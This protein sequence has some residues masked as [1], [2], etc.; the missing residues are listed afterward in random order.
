MRKTAM[1]IAAVCLM[2]SIT[3]C[4]AVGGTTNESTAPGTTGNGSNAPGAIE[5]TAPGTASNGSTAPGTGANESNTPEPAA[6]ETAGPVTVTDQSGREVVIGGNVERIVSGYYISSSVCIA[7][8]LA[9][10]LVGIEARANERPIYALAK[11]ELMNLTS[12]G[13]A[14]DFNLEACLELK[15]DLVILPARLRDVADTMEDM[16]VPV[17]L[18]NPESYREL[19]DM[20]NLIG[21]ATRETA[22]A[23]QLTDWIENSRKSVDSL[24]VSLSDKPVVYMCG[25]GSWLSTTPNGMFQASL[26]EL[27]GGRN[28]AGDIEGSGRIDISYEQLFLLNPDIIIVPP[29]AGFTIDDVLSDPLLTELSAVKTRSVYQMPEAFEAWDSPVPSFMLGVK[30]LLSVLYGDVYS[31]EMLRVDAADYYMEFYGFIVDSTLIS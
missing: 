13:T 27:A 11:P 22:R 12:V 31:I 19:I 16:G 4:N 17:I 14:R 20:V 9:D 6:T 28:A 7:L 18:V 3:A 10:K 5:S 2:I 15:P 26:I 25:T 8:G 23:S 21:Q 29:E 1:L 24:T 30:W